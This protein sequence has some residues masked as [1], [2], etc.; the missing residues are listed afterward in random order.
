IFMCGIAGI[1]SLNELGPRPGKLETV[2]QMCEILSHRGPDDQG[3]YDSESVTLGMRRLAVIDINSGQQPMIS[4]NKE[5]V[6]VFNG[7]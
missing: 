7:E 4:S 1:V 3:I 5:A 2:T 6:I